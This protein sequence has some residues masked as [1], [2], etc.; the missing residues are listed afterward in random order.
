MILIP[1]TLFSISMAVDV[2]LMMTFSYIFVYSICMLASSISGNIVTQIVV[3]LLVLFLI[4][5]TRIAMLGDINYGTTQTIKILVGAI[6]DDKTNLDML[7]GNTHVV[8]NGT[9]T[10][11]E[12]INIK[13][14]TFTSSRAGWDGGGIYFSK[15]NNIEII[16]SSFSNNYAYRSNGGALA[17]DG[18]NYAEIKNSQFISNTADNLGGAVYSNI[19]VNIED[20]NF[21]QNTAVNRFGGAVNINGNIKNCIFE[22]NKAKV[23]YICY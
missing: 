18:G 7:S 11:S 15:S 12:N 3:S 13:N 22:K 5:F 8:L 10:N 14:C 17:F 1:S 20:S 23:L 16:D 19:N 2:F 6:K 21:T 9:Y 4:P